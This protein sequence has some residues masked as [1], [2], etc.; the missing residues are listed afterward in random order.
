MTD[1]PNNAPAPDSVLDEAMP[2][3]PNLGLI[4]DLKVREETREEWI[5]GLSQEQRERVNRIDAL[6]KRLR[7][8]LQRHDLVL[9]YEATNE[10]LERAE[11]AVLIHE[12]D[13][14]VRNSDIPVAGRNLIIEEKIAEKA[15]SQSPL[16]RLRLLLERQQDAVSEAELAKATAQQ[17]LKRVAAIHQRIVALKGEVAA[18]RNNLI[19]AS[20]SH[21]IH[22][23]RLE[24]I[25]AGDAV[26]ARFLQV[27]APPHNSGDP[28]RNARII[29]GGRLMLEAVV[30]DWPLVEATL[31]HRIEGLE[32]ELSKLE[33]EYT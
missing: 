24:E 6:N 28:D 1:E 33:S 22:L 21:A 29:D 12:V 7:E 32:Q 31:T 30:K 15:A 8:E 25:S 5:V 9:G 4:R 19:W 3:G 2:E 13:Q 20:Q 11:R 27:S 23:A 26:V 16:R 10:A 14:E 17:E 18:A